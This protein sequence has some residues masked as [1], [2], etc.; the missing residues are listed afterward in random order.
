MLAD[1]ACVLLVVGPCLSTFVTQACEEVADPW[2]PAAPFLAFASTASLE[3]IFA[4]VRSSREGFG[5]RV[6]PRR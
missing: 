2:M 1:W 5:A 6:R 3:I 4:W